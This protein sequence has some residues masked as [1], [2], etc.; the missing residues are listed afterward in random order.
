MTLRE[1]GWRKAM[2]GRT[3]VDEVLRI[4]KGDHDLAELER[5]TSGHREV[6]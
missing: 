6:R 5:I 4:T 3:T 2:D 1:D